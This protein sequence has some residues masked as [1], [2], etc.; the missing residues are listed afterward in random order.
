MFKAD[1]A[2]LWLANSSALTCRLGADQK[3]NV[4]DAEIRAAKPSTHL[5]NG[6]PSFVEPRSVWEILAASNAS[7]WP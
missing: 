1:V 4:T 6:V 2:N 5:G 7:Q 3:R